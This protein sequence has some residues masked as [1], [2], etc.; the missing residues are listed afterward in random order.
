MTDC[1]VSRSVS[2]NFGEPMIEG[3]PTVT[4]TVSVGPETSNVTVS[5]AVKRWV[6][7]V[8]ARIWLSACSTVKTPEAPGEA[9]LPISDFIIITRSPV[10]LWNVLNTVSRGPGEMS[11]RRAATM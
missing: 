3:T 10:T 11:K 8:P 9:M 6:T 7:P 4:S 2:V 5:G 1:G